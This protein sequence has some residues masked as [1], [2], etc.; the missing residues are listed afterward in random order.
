MVFF[1]ELLKAVLLVG[2]VILA[3]AGCNPDDSGTNAPDNTFIDPVYYSAEYEPSLSVDGKYVYFITADTL[4]QEKN[5]IYRADVD[6]PRREKIL[7]GFGFHSPVQFPDQS[8]LAFLT[9]GTV[10]Y[11]NFASGA[12][13]PAGVSGSYQSIVFIN[14]NL[15]IGCIGKLL[16]LINTETSQVS[17]FGSGCDPTYYA[18]NQIIAL[19]DRTGGIWGVHKF[20]YSM[21]S[22]GTEITVDTLALIAAEGDI[23]WLSLEPTRDRYVYV[24]DRDSVGLVFTGQLGVSGKYFIAETGHVKAHMLDFNQLIYQGPDGRFYKSDFIGSYH[25]PFWHAEDSQ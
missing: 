12:V 13:S 21:N 20:T 24:E 10:N 8:G 4:L 25:V 5:G 23:R 22:E 18:P 2:P 1:R 17:Q 3:V 11:L 15:M 16:Y 6:S 14:D 9:G 19:S 7:F